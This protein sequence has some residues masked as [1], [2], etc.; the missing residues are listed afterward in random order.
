MTLTESQAVNVLQVCAFLL[1]PLLF[2]MS[3]SPL[4]L[5]MGLLMSCSPEVGYSCLDIIQPALGRRLACQELVQQRLLRQIWHQDINQGPRTAQGNN[6]ISQ[7]DR[8]LKA[9]IDKLTP[10]FLPFHLGE[11][12]HHTLQIAGV[13]ITGGR[14]RQNKPSFISFPSTNC[15]NGA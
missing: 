12:Q 10:Q 13:C 3:S 1:F 4:F 8:N 7:A 2:L 5:Y 15:G 6:P 14:Q 11:E 9:G